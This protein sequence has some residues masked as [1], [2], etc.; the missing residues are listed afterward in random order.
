MESKNVLI[1]NGYFKQGKKDGIHITTLWNQKTI[2]VTK[3]NWFNVMGNYGPDE[4]N[5]YR[6]VG[7][8]SQQ[9]LAA[10]RNLAQ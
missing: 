6:A 5:C 1:V 7:W 10:L 2:T 8:M 9:D 3:D 4:S